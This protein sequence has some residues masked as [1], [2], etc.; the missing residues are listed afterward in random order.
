MREWPESHPKARAM[1]R[2]KSEII[3]AA[4]RCFI[5]TGYAKTTME[6]VAEAAGI[7]LMTLYR[8]AESKED[9]FAATVTDACRARDENERQY[10][11]NLVNLPVREMLITSGIEMRLKILHPDSI[12]LMRLVIAEADSFPAL[13]PLAYGAFIEHFEELALQ[14]IRIGFPHFSGDAD[15]L[16]RRYVDCLLGADVLRILLGCDPSGDS[17][18]FSKAELAAELL[19]GSIG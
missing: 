19:L 7:S 4:K 12:A 13:L 5:R 15:I 9:L 8:F 6:T 17:Q 11:E 14:V 1:A 16:S 18:D 3:D 2:R 10:Y